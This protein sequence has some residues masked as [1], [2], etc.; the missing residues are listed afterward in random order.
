[1]HRGYLALALLCSGSA[2]AAA[3]APAVIPAQTVTFK[4][5]IVG[6]DNG[7]ACQ[8]VALVPDNLPTD[9]LTLAVRR[10]VGSAGEL[11]IEIAGFAPAVGGYRILVDSRPV[12][13]GTIAVGADAIRIT[14]LDA[15]K[16]ARAMARG[17]AFRLTDQ[18]GAV[19]GQVSL[20]GATAALRAI[21]SAQ[22]RA[23]SRGAIV[24]M[25]R[26]ATPAKR[27]TQVPLILAGRIQPSAMLPDTAALVALSESSPCAKERV[28]A[29]QDAAFS[30]GAT[31]ALVLLNCGAGAYN[32]SAGAYIGKRDDAGKWTFN[33][34][35]FDYA[36]NRLTG[37]SDTA[38]LV[39]ATWDSATQTI[40]SFSKGRGIGDCGTSED[41]VWDGASFRLVKARVMDQCRGSTDWIPVWRAEVKFTG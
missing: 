38:L 21:D 40:S 36:P 34:A 39:D 26:R 3:G 24:A 11:A 37:G 23:G 16:L 30:L 41:Y 15:T 20:S 28:G 29:T 8:A 1:M 35:S 32:A 7:L 33:P 5:W 12:N 10:S 6:C 9:A 14:G 18:S 17:R 31:K 19:I 25:G 4:D 2:A 27:N 13:S 22:G